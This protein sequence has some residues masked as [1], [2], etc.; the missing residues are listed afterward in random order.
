MLFRSFVNDVTK[1]A[2]QQN[3]DPAIVLGLIRRESVFDPG[4]RSAAGAIGLMQ[5]MP[6]T[7]VTIAERLNEKWASAGSLYQ[8][9]VN[10]KY[11]SF[12][13]K[14]MLNKFG[15]HFALAAA[16]YNAGPG[17][18]NQWLPHFRSVPADVWIETIPFK[19]TRE[20]VTAVLGYAIIYQQRLNRDT[21]RAGDFMR[22]VTPG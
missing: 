11:G 20:Y 3:L 15:G 1:Y 12:Y 14:Q 22:D 5:I 2:D 4:A 21:L 17:R 13:Y 8:T 16:A 19:E 6:Q 9:D 10:V 18:V 7:G